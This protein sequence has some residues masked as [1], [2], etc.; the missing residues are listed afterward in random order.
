[1]WAYDPAFTG[2]VQVAVGD[3]D[4]DGRAEIVT[5]PGDGG[6]ADVRAFAADGHP[7]RPP[8]VAFPG[9]VGARVA[10]LPAHGHGV[11]LAAPGRRGRPWVRP[12][13]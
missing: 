9:P 5:G 7:A 8:T 3:L 4:G 1:L 11:V 10:V 6:G 2:G 13:G 12:L